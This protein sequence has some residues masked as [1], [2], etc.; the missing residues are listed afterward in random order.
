M[1]GIDAGCHYPIVLR[2]PLTRKSTFFDQE[3]LCRSLQF[4]SPALI[5]PVE[6]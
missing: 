6:V 5:N 2:A 3:H 1:V 4:T